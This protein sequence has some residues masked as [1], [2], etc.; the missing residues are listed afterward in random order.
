M[1]S[2]DSLDLNARLSLALELA[3]EAGDITLKYF[4]QD[5]FEVERKS[6]NSPVTQ[7]DREAEQWMRKRLTEAFPEDG[8][9]GEEFG[10]QPGQSGA[11]WILDPIDGTKSFICGVPL[12]AVLIGLEHQQKSV[13]G[14]IHIP[15]LAEGVYAA[16]GQGAWSYRGDADKQPA[17]VSERPLSEGLFTTSQSGSFAERGA[18]EAFHELE[19]AAYIARTWGDAYG[20]MLVATGRAE[21]MIDPEMSIWDAAAL[22]P[23]MEEAGGSF[24]DWRGQPTIHSGEGVGCNQASLSQVLEITKRYPSS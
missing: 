15:A 11:R 4:R 1:S 16:S 8:I 6:D 22:Q 17:R 21:V 2:H 3:K 9:V 23:I 10:E 24:T 12:Y 5:N 14:V 7:A 18:G 19:K 20:Y 13:L